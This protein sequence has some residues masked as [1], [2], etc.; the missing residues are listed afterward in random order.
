MSC[1]RM[2]MGDKKERACCMDVQRPA[3]HEHVMRACVTY[4]TLQQYNITAAAYAKTMHCCVPGSTHSS[5]ELS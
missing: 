5:I 3:S 4:N 2:G 1:I